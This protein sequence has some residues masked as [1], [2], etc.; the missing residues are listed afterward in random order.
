MSADGAQ[1][2]PW[3]AVPWRTIVA[4][5]AVVALTL[6]GIAFVL[7]ASGTVLL[8]ARAAFIAIVVAPVVGAL[9]RRI[10]VPRTLASF[11]VV[12]GTL[13]VAAG[14]IALFL[15]PLRHQIAS[16]LSDLPGTVR[17]AA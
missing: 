12:L 17:D 5:T 11:V 4:A 14:V 1:P 2:G 3:A 6:G 8:V 13:I 9:E 7:A 15:L 16:I 10:G